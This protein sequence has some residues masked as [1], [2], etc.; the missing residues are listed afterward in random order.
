[1]RKRVVGKFGLLALGLLPLVVVAAGFRVA[2]PWMQL[3]PARAAMLGTVAMIFVMGYGFFMATRVLRWQRRLDEVHIASQAFAN[4]YGWVYGGL[5]TTLL[6]MVPPVMSW[7]VSLAYST[8]NVPRISLPDM[9]AD[10]AVRMAFFYGISLTLLVQG[11]VVSLASM[12][13]WRRIGGLGKQA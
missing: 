8:A 13:W 2:M 5:A 9:A 1:M 4:S 3:D 11:L 6:L 12:I 7:V 10:R